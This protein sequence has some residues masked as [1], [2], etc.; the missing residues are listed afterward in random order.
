MTPKLS[1]IT[2]NLNN[3]AGL[4]KT[5]ESTVS[6]S[7][8]DFEYIVIDG[9]SSDEST[10]VIRDFNDRITYWVSEPDKGIYSAMNKGIQKAEG[11][12]LQFLNSG[13]WLANP[14]VLEEVIKYAG[15]ADILYGDTI[16]YY[17]TKGELKEARFPDKFTFDYFFTSSIPH[18]SSFIK[19]ELFDRYGL[20]DESFRIVSDWEFFLLTIIKHNTTYLHL[21]FPISVYDMNGMSENPAN[22]QLMASEVKESLSRHFPNFLPDYEELHR[23]RKELDLMKKKFGFKLKH[24]LITNRYA[25]YI[26]NKLN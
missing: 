9:G 1:I 13:D 14:C 5:I 8:R 7:F 2:V 12:Y 20:Y 4:R 10:H 19:R 16:N 11:T 26:L 6:Q 21:K 23:L 17:G 18:P 15:K 3:A 22:K 24:S 25:R